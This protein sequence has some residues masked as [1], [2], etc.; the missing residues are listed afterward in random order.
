MSGAFSA[1]A[2]TL[3]SIMDAVT[4]R[5]VETL[6][7]NT[8]GSFAPFQAPLDIISAGVI[9]VPSIMCSL[10]MEV[11]NKMRNLLFKKI[12]IFY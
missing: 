5:H 12:N 11:N 10:G 9:A 4:G 8:I 7:E 6:M 3:S 1:C 2:R